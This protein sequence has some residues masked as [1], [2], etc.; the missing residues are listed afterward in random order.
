M[1]TL[2]NPFAAHSFFELELLEQDHAVYRL[3]IRPESKNPFGMVH[4]G[5][6]Y[7]MADD[8]ASTAA[9]SDGRQYVTQTGTLHFLRNQTKGVIRA[10]RRIRRRGRS[11][12]LAS[13]EIT[14]EAGDLLAAGDFVYFC[15]GKAFSDL[16]YHRRTGTVGLSAP[17]S[18]RGKAAS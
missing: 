9:S 12:V 2:K 3:D 16:P 5:A 4:G 13:V 17:L 15:V 8:A 14:N 10:E 18:A 11:T 1:R 6:L 7:T